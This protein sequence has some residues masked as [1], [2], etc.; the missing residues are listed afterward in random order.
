[1]MPFRVVCVDDKNK[2]KEV[3][4]SA[5]VQYGERYTV[6]KVDLL[7]SHKSIGFKLQEI[8]LPEES[9]PYEYFDASRFILSDE[10]EEYLIEQEV[11]KLINESR[12]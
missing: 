3:P 7:S 8:E 6:V 9:F 12:K 4:Q 2:P 1:M 10:S 5:W 11:N